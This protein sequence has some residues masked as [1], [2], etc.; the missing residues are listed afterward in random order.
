MEIFLFIFIMYIIFILTLLD[1]YIE[2]ITINGKKKYIIWY[3]SKNKRK[4]ITIQW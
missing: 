4:Y 3:N 1:P 2:T